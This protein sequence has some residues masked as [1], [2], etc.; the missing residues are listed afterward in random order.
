MRPPSQP[1]PNRVSLVPAITK[2]CFFVFGDK[3]LNHFMYNILNSAHHWCDKW[4][5]I[6]TKQSSFDEPR[7]EYQTLMIWYFRVLHYLNS[8]QSA[9]FLISWVFGILLAN[10]T[11]G[12]CSKFELQ[13][14]GTRGDNKEATKEP[15]KQ[16]SSDKVQLPWYDTWNLCDISKQLPQSVSGPVGQWV[17]LS[18]KA[19]AS[20]FIQI[21]L[22]IWIFINFELSIQ[23]SCIQVWSCLSVC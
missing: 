19:V 2:G 16:N 22:H 4:K 14:G 12:K 3:T 20:M 10:S 21:W 17:L 6:N 9:L 15:G 8:E 11:R 18:E 1:F 23:T 5:A 13:I 7:M